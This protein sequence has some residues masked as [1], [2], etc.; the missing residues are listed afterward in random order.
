MKKVYLHQDTGDPMLG[1]V[2]EQEIGVA[3]IVLKGACVHVGHARLEPGQ[4]A[5]EDF[6]DCL[7]VGHKCL[8]ALDVPRTGI[9][10]LL[11]HGE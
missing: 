1:S 4:V 2:Q 8:S 11:L 5:V 6:G 9:A 10:T 3:T 7:T